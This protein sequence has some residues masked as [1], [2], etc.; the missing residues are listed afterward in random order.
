MGLLAPPG[1]CD[2]EGYRCLGSLVI[3]CSPGDAGWSAKVFAACAR[4][5][6]QEGESL[7][8]EEADPEGAARIL[9]AR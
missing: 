9:C 8:E 1:A 5:C 7:G 4:G 6:F 2:A 3:A